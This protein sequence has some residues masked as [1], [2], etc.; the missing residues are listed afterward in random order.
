MH[1]SISE[2][3]KNKKKIDEIKDFY[4]ILVFVDVIKL[5]LMFK[6]IDVVFSMR[7]FFI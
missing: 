6:I 4:K 3:L 5:I 1:F 7:K 2:A